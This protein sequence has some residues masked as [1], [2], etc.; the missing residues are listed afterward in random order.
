MPSWVPGT[1]RQ[2]RPVLWPGRPQDLVGQGPKEGQVPWNKPNTMGGSAKQ[3]CE[4][5]EAETRMSTTEYVGGDGG[6]VAESP[7]KKAAVSGI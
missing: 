1:Q 7:P 6:E 3:G 5:A 2:R 4:A